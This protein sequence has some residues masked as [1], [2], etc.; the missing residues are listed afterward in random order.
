MNNF[1]FSINTVLESKLGFEAYFV[2]CCVHSKNKQL[3]NNYTA[4]CNKIDT[5]V[6]RKLQL[7]GFLD[8]KDHEGDS[9]YFDLL[10]L[11]SKGEAFFENHKTFD[12]E[13]Q[14]G[15]FRLHYPMRVKE[16]FRSRPLQGN[17]SK[18]KKLYE[19]LL[20]E[21]THDILCKCAELYTNEKFKSGDQ[22]FMQSLEAWL[23]QKNYQIYLN[24][25]DNKITNNSQ[26]ED[27]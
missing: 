21:T 8:I 27:I 3:I 2:L 19:K 10:S 9:I 22:I 17:L 11:T 12:L 16:G 7:D 15:E 20:L 1:E 23:F 5:K 24:E 18:C 4:N 26:S 13:K 25:I 14:F 6:F